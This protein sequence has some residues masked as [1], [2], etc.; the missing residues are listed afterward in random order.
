MVRDNTQPGSSSLNGPWMERLLAGR[1]R[2]TAELGHG[3]ASNVYRA[4][5]LQILGRQ[6][7]LKVA[8]MDR[9][10]TQTGRARAHLVHEAQALA[11]LHHPALPPLYDVLIQEEHY[12]LVLEYLPGLTLRQIAARKPVDEAELLDWALRL[13]DVLV[14]LHGHPTHPLTHGAVGA[15]HCMLMPEGRLVLFDFGTADPVTDAGRWQDAR[16]VAILCAGLLGNIPGEGLSSSPA[17]S[18]V[19]KAASRT[20]L[21]LLFQQAISGEMLTV[22]ALRARLQ[23]VA[24]DMSLPWGICQTCQARVRIQ[25]R[26]CG[27]CGATMRRESNQHAPQAA[28]DPTFELPRTAHA[29]L[30]WSVENVAAARHAGVASSCPRGRADG[31]PKPA[32]RSSAAY[33]WPIPGSP[34]AA[35]CSH[36]GEWHGLLCPRAHAGRDAGG[37]SSWHARQRPAQC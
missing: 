28:A 17:T 23:K 10:S 5:D 3:S 1:Y 14:Y 13:C 22:P 6:V 19:D 26:Y 21:Q 16:A 11:A 12:A 9:L 36:R 15:A 8:R 4:S 29:G 30:K 7:A 32:L 18:S 24:A 33:S 2:I 34:T 20:A 25:A 35:Q 27:V 31:V 37:R